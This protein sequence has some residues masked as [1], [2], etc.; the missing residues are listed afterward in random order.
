MGFRYIVAHIFHI[1][2]YPVGFNGLK[3]EDNTSAFGRF[4][5]M[6]EQMDKY[7]TQTH[8]VGKYPAFVKIRMINHFRA[9]I[10]F[11]V[12]L[13]FAYGVILQFIHQVV[14][15]KRFGMQNYLF[16][17]DFG[18]IGELVLPGHIFIINRL[19]S[20]KKA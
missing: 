7:L 4:N 15:A 11:V 10:R 16:L 3:T 1:K 5:R 6:V 9:N 14:N 2:F 8:P 20:L 13:Q 12:V 18:N 17:Y 19:Q